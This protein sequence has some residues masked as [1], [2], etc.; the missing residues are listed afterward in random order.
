MAHSYP[1]TL[2]GTPYHGNRNAH[3]TPRPSA[4]RPY[5]RI[6]SY[7]IRSSIPSECQVLA[8]KLRTR[9][10]DGAAEHFSIEHGA[11]LGRNKWWVLQ[12][13]VDPEQNPG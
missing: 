10:P 2:L 1:P 11:E 4:L 13:G 9:R 12:H 3:S 7:A 5:E 8:A 6:S